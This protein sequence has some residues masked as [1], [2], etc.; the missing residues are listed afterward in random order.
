MNNVFSQKNLV[1]G[2]IALLSL[3]F[4]IIPPATVPEEMVT[5]VEDELSAPI[6]LENVAPW[7]IM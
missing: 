5:A 6:V 2:L 1:L 7:S 4:L 3:K